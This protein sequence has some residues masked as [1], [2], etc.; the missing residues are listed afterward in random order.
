MYHETAD[1]QSLPLFVIAA[2]NVLLLTAL[3]LG[4]VSMWRVGSKRKRSGTAG[5]LQD[6]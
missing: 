6:S 1:L 4:V 3:I 2:R 5:A